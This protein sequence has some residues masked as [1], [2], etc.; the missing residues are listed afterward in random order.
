MCIVSNKKDKQGVPVLKGSVG[1]AYLNNI[2]SMRLKQNAVAEAL[3]S[4]V[5]NITLVNGI[6]NS[7]MQVKKVRDTIQPDFEKK[8]FHL[9]E[10]PPI[11]NTNPCVNKVN[12]PISEEENYKLLSIRDVARHNRMFAQKD[13]WPDYS[14]SG[15]K[16]KMRLESK[17]G[18]EPVCKGGTSLA[19]FFWLTSF[20]MTFK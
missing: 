11:Q 5:E 10:T 19:I 3:L 1:R 8:N 16:I 6:Q 14:S 7:V 12:S 17:L 13:Q 15:G 18:K 2:V 4:T 9:I 20:S